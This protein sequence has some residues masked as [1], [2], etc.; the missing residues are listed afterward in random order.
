VSAATHVA[1]RAGV[2]PKHLGWLGVGLGVLAWYIALPPLLV[3][4]PVP[5]LLIAAMAVAAG[6]VAVRNDE[7][8]VG[9]GAV[10]AGVVGAIGAVV[11]TRSGEA[12]LEDVFVWSALIAAMLRFATPLT[13]AALGG[14]LSERSGV[15]NIG[16]EGMMLIG[17]FFGIFGADLTGSWLLGAVIGMAAGAVTGLVHAVL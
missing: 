10:A 8:R 9:Y 4:T 15:I 2:A 16:L 14:M 3:R 7:K 6:A 5:S 12:N 17:A 13:F 11:A 1:S